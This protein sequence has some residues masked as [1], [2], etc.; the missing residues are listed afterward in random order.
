MR[1]MVS[2]GVT[3]DFEEEDTAVHDVPLRPPAPAEVVDRP[4]DPLTGEQVAVTRAITEPMGSG[5]G[6]IRITIETENF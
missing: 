1:I 4:R 3:I 2:D 5:P 6:R